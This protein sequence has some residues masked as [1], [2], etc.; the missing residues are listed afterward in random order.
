MGSLKPNEVSIGQF[1][2]IAGNRPLPADNKILDFAQT[3]EKLHGGLNGSTRRDIGGDKL[4]PDVLTKLIPPKDKETRLEPDVLTKLTPPEDK[5]TR[6]EPDVLTKRTPP[7]DEEYKLER[8]VL[9]KQDP[10]K[11]IEPTRQEE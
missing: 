4:E 3:D 5:E 2:K 7:K 1:S 10:P 6:L 8:D 11:Y 9:T